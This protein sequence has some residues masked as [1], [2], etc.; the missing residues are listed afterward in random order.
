MRTCQKIFS[1]KVTGAAPPCPNDVKDL[2]WSA[3]PATTLPGDS[4]AGAMAGGSGSATCVAVANGDATIHFQTT[5]CN[6]GLGYN[7][8][9]HIDMDWDHPPTV[10]ADDPDTWWQVSASSGGGFIDGGD[11]FG[12]GGPG[13]FSKDIP[14]MCPPGG[15]SLDLFFEQAGLGTSHVTWTVTPLTHP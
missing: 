4:A 3:V 14:V 1:L 9:V 7:L 2:V 12:L 6:T 8:N 15:V 13:T 11:T 5:L 10:L